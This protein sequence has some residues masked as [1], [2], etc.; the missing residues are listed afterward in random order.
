M[1]DDCQQR[2]RRLSNN[3]KN[4]VIVLLFCFKTITKPS[5]LAENKVGNEN[6]REDDE[7]RVKLLPLARA[8]LQNDIAQYAEAYTIGYTVTQHHGNHGD[9]GRKGFAYFP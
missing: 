7:C 5:I 4:N 9:K 2:V 3:E 8:E 1:Y 6:E